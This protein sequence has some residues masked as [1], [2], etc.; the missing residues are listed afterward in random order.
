M[1]CRSLGLSCFTLC[2]AAGLLVTLG[3]NKPA[4]E[5]VIYCALDSVFAEPVLNDFETQSGI[6]VRV[7]YDTEAAK[8]TGLAQSLLN[9]R[10]HPRCDVFWNNEI[11]HTLRLAEEGILAS[12]PS[13]FSETRPAQWRDEHYEWTAMAAR[14]RVLVYNP[15]TVKA[16][17]LPAFVS[18]LKHPGWQGRLV[19][20]KPLFGT[21]ATHMAA[22]HALWGRQGFVDFLDALKQN[23]VQLADGNASVVRLVAAG[24][25]EIGL[26]DTDDVFM[27]LKDSQPIAWKMIG[28]DPEHPGS[29]LIPNT[30]AI[31]K[32][33]P[34]TQEAMALLDYLLSPEVEARLAASDSHQIPLQ[35]GLTT[36][37]EIPPFDI[38]PVDY[39]DAA[40][41]LEDVFQLIKDSLL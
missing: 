40:S 26:T 10:N 6:R 1:K 27:A 19:I 36:P 41:R 25:F 13:E 35:P 8:T 37:D 5:V 32:D 22:L 14:A 31:I 28:Q 38:H 16:E 20:A 18:D 17:D 24:E 11:V 15:S 23:K 2:V 30:V 3:C 9:E 29:L 4:R 39:R 21:T 33:A 12:Y 34:H 7:K